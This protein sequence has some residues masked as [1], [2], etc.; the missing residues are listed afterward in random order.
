MNP[1]LAGSKKTQT[2]NIYFFFIVPTFEEN[3]ISM[4]GVVSFIQ[5]LFTDSN[6]VVYK[7]FYTP[8]WRSEINF[9][10]SNVKSSFTS[11]YFL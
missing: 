6:N 3:W 11:Y 4:L 2:Q 9:L 1:N 10:S 5:T 7:K 8:H